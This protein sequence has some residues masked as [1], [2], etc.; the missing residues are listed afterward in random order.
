MEQAFRLFCFPY[1]GASA[2]IYASWSRKLPRWI[3]VHPVELPGRGWRASE[4]LE[5]SMEGLVRRA[6]QSVLP[7]ARAPFAL[8]GHSL[9]AVLAYELACILTHQHCLG[10]SILFA[11]G[12]AAPSQRNDARY[13]RLDSD[14]QLVA[15]L[16]QFE[17]TPREVLAN[18]ELMRLLLP[19]LRADFTV[20]GGYQYR[21]RPL[22]RCPI[23]VMVGRE[24]ITSEAQRVQAWRTHTSAAC[25]VASFAGGHFFVHEDREA[26][27]DLV[28]RRLAEL[29]P[30][31]RT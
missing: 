8:F 12:T 23:Q 20:C 7:H 6:Q 4:P 16:E 26:L 22:L 25:D 14:E 29:A 21:P 31:T 15:E 3:E 10:P 9:G 17:G 13:A 18:A 28:S 11:S 24:D 5:T 19:V 1:S 2:R 30:E 27:L